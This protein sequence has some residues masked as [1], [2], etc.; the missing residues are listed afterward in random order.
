MYPKPNL[1]HRLGLS[2][3]F[4][5]SLF[6]GACASQH[7]LANRP[8]QE[9]IHFATTLP[10]V[11]KSEREAAGTQYMITTQGDASSK[12]GKRMF[13]LGGNAIDAAIAISFAISVERPQST[14]IGGGGFMLIH[15]ADSKETI[16]V[17]FRETAP[18]LASEKMYLDRFGKVIPKLSLDGALSVGTPGLVAG[19][20]EI[21]KKYGALKWQD[22]VQPSIDLAENGFP[23]YPHLNEA[24]SQRA[25]VL[26][27]FP[28]SKKLFFDTNG[29]PLAI[30]STLRQRDLAR[31][32]R[33][34]Q[35]EGRDGFYKGSVAKAIVK[36]QKK[37]G[38]LIRE[39]DLLDYKVK[40]RR[41]VWGSY[42]NYKIA[43]MPPPSSGGSHIIQILNILEGY[44]LKDDGPFSE[45]TIHLTTSA[46]QRAF[47]D[48]ATYLG[49]SDFV[50]VPVTGLT[51]K[52]YASDLRQQITI[53]LAMPSQ[54]VKPGAPWPYNTPYESDETTHFT[55]MDKLGNTVAST[56]TINYYFGSGVVAEG[57]GII[58]NDEMDDFSAKPGAKNVFGAVGSKKNR[59]QPKKR[60]LS[61]MSPTIV[62]RNDSD[63]PM[64]ALGTPSGTR[65]ITCVVQTMLNYLLYDM[66]LYESVASLRYHHQWAPDEIFVDEPGFTKEL[67]FGLQK[68]GHSVRTRNL[69]CRVNAIAREDSRLIGVSD[70]R[71]EGLSIGE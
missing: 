15:F 10:G 25:E 9:K 5:C 24:I 33:K 12:A 26:K 67:K 34:I 6:S 39:D 65:I 50:K 52:K 35:K 49:D 46:M 31:T 19:L 20:Y 60:P 68:R 36:S 44:S 71:G 61:S 29:E 66:P 13:A 41:P 8:T 3:I 47:A 1:L 45:Q 70:P 54:N 55:V 69:G 4:L 28:D 48:R 16:A 27:K 22:V 32:L 62:F 58:L 53:D 38:G 23:V 40:F 7:P 42:L 51:S 63:V 14:G 37:H 18:N 17:D 57:T 2:A 21:H 56:Q 59:I 43:S 64:L 30:G 11:G